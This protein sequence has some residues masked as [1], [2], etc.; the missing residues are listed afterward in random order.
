MKTRL[1]QLSRWGLALALALPAC[2]KAEEAPLRV[3]AASSLAEVLQE[4]DAA[5]TKETG[6][7]VALNLGASSL[8]ERQIE[9]GAPCD[10]FLSADAAKM[11]AL[12]KKGFLLAGTRED[13]LSNT[14]VLVVPRESTLVIASEQDLMRQEIHRIATGNPAAV[15]VGIYAK[16]HWEKLGQWAAVESKILSCENVRAALAA[17]EAG[18]VEVGIVYKTDA[19]ISKKV[20]IAYEIPAAAGPSIVYPMAVLK[21]AAQSAQARQYLDYL[22]TPASHASFAKFGFIV[23]PEANAKP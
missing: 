12:E 10:V 9:E 1:L 21:A 3:A 16:A 17:V 22:D 13:Q 20:K 6:V 4:I 23:L 7:K 14:L 11:D 5:F 18:N 2:K 8:L 15:P 19:G